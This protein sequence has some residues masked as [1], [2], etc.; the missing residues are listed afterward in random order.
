VRRYL[1]L[2]PIKARLLRG[3]G[4]DGGR[5]VEQGRGLGRGGRKVGDAAPV[6][7]L[8]LHGRPRI[9]QFGVGQHGAD[10]EPAREGFELLGGEAGPHFGATY[11]K[12]LGNAA[13]G[14]AHSRDA[15]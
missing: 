1:V 4:R 6:G 15:G 3:A 14:L 11:K 10:R 13:A 2:Q 8:L 5:R 9:V 7:E 12:E